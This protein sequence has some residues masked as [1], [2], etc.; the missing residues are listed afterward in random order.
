M[1]G[2]ECA[3]DGRLHVSERKKSSST[4]TRVTAKDMITE[5]EEAEDR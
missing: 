2:A 1:C 4:T 3:A 5:T